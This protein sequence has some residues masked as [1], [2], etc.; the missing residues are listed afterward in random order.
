[1]RSAACL[2]L[3]CTAAASA[4]DAAVPCPTGLPRAQA[5]A[6]TKAQRT[7]S[8]HNMLQAEKELAEKLAAWD[9]DAES[10]RTAG[11]N[12]L[13]ARHTFKQYRAA[14]C[15]LAAT[16]AGAS[17]AAQNI[18]RNTCMAELN[19]RRAEQIRALADSMPQRPSEKPSAA[20]PDP[21]TEEPL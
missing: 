3:L 13:Y 11:Q 5:A 7:A 6:C 8:K 1:M 10:V 4:A 2:L 14:Q 21:E 20:P 17:A 12:M 18:R 15:R 19:N 9:A 16:L